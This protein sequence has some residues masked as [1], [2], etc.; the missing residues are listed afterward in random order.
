MEGTGRAPAF[1]RCGR[2]LVGLGGAGGGGAPPFGL[3]GTRDGREVCRAAQPT[4]PLTRTDP[5]CRP[6]L[7]S[8]PPRAAAH[9]GA[10]PA[11]QRG[12]GRGSAARRPR[13]PEPRQP[14]SAATRPGPRSRR[15]APRA[16]RG[17]RRRP[18]PGGRG[19]GSGG[20]GRNG[21]PAVPAAGSAASPSV[22]SAQAAASPSRAAPSPRLPRRGLTLH[23]TGQSLMEN[24]P[25]FR[26][27]VRNFDLPWSM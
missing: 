15:A 26:Q 9:P 18:P 20:S 27:R 6:C 25:E 7:T 24:L 4:S 14:P 23:C 22:S 16:P 8:T 13:A 10:F 19:P 3:S 1:G 21:G 17:P 12:K 2:P 11:G 5:T